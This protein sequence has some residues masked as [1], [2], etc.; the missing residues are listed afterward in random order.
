M[1]EEATLEQRKLERRD[2]VSAAKAEISAK[3]LGDEPTSEDK[4]SFDR[5]FDA[6]QKAIIRKRIAVDKSRPDGRAADEI[7]P[8]AV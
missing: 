3:V 1:L 7:R 4:S 6:L 2:K 8:I 5:A